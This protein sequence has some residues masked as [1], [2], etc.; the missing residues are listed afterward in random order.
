MIAFWAGVCALLAPAPV[1]AIG[2]LVQAPA[3]SYDHDASFPGTNANVA[4]SPGLVTALDGPSDQ[5]LAAAQAQFPGWTFAW[6]GQSFGTMTINS[7]QATA[8][9]TSGGCQMDLTYTLVVADGPL[10][11]LHWVQF[12]WTDDPLGGATSPYIDPVPN[13]DNLPFYWTLAEDTMYKVGTNTYNF[14]DNQ[15][16]GYPPA[17]IFPIPVAGKSWNAHLYLVLCHS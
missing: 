11:R 13:D 9:A 8:G 2:T 1:S 5:E 4:L 14:S 15:S 17:P 12:I 7:Y 10:D 6:G 16:R 3:G